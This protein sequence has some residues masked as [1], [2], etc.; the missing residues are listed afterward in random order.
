MTFEWE[1]QWFSDLSGVHMFAYGQGQRQHRGQFTDV[2]RWTGSAGEAL[3]PP[4]PDD[5]SAWQDWDG[6]K[7]AVRRGADG[8]ADRVDRLRLCG[9]GVVPQQADYALRC[10]MERL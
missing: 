10:L 4:G 9:N 8:L 2:G 5:W 6:P 1:V 7:P 3:W